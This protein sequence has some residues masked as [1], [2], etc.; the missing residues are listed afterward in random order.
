MDFNLADL[1]ECVAARV[2]DRDAVVWGDTRLNF[3]QLDER[4]TR[5]AHGL[6]ALAPAARPAETEPSST[7]REPDALAS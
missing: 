2:P 1:F 7:S 5:L 3:A 4:A 6:A